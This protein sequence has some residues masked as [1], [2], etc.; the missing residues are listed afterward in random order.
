MKSYT[1]FIGRF[2]PFTIA[3]KQIVDYVLKEYPKDKIIFAIG[4]SNCAYRHG[5]C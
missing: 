3:H 4:S 5:K 2:Q 1:V